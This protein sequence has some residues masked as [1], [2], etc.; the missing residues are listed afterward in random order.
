[1]IFCHFLQ[2]Y[3][4]NKRHTLFSGFFLR[5]E[6]CNSKK[7]KK[8]R[9]KKPKQTTKKKRK[10]KTT[11]PPPPK[12]R[13]NRTKRVYACPIFLMVKKYSIYTT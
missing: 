6:I 7:K 11:T 9:K 4:Q 12:K 3:E 8:K 13:D 10:E 2:I 1:M 5:S